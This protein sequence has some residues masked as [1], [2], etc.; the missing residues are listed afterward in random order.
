[1]I[2]VSSQRPGAERA[3]NNCFTLM[4]QQCATSWKQLLYQRLKSDP[5]LCKLNLTTIKTQG[6]RPQKQGKTKP[7]SIKDGQ[8]T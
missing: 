8:R 6:Y 7:S 1:M 2:P 5:S 4:Q 3:P